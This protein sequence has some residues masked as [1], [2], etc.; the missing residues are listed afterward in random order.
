[1]AITL[2]DRA[3]LG[4]RNT[5]DCIKWP[6][7]RDYGYPRVWTGS[8]NEYV[9]TMLYRTLIGDIPEGKVAGHICWNHWCVNVHHLEL[10]DKVSLG[11]IY[12]PAKR[13]HH[14]WT[15]ARMVAADDRVSGNVQKL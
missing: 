8:T 6:G 2:L 14:R 10:R 7:S 5:T 9:H 4:Q 3:F 11:A 1:M 15:T 12:T 13:R